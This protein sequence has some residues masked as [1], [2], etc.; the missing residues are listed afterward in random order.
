MHKCSNPVNKIDF[1]SS[2]Y[3]CI[4][5]KLPLQ[6]SNYINLPFFSTSSMIFLTILVG[7]K[8]LESV[9]QFSSLKN[10]TPLQATRTGCKRIPSVEDSAQ[11]THSVSTRY[12]SGAITI[13]R[14][15]SAVYQNNEVY[16]LMQN[17]LQRWGNHAPEIM[18]PFL[19]SGISWWPTFSPSD[20][21]SFTEVEVDTGFTSARPSSSSS[22]LLNLLWLDTLGF[23]NGK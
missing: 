15:L 9:S 13:A 3:P 4:S 19:S 5:V 2:W 11:C 16:S 17:Q 18:C 14:L 12:L 10:I 7:C 6:Y 8:L 22:S 23:C 1:N 21:I 20:P